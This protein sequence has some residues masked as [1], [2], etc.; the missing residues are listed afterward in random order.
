[1]KCL[2]C[3]EENEGNAKFCFKCGH[4]VIEKELP[5]KNRKKVIAFLCGAVILVMIVVAIFVHQIVTQNRLE[6][7]RI[8][9][10]IESKIEAEKA[11]KEKIALYISD[12]KELF[13]LMEGSS[14]NF[15]MLGVMYDTSTNLKE[16]G[17]LSRD[18]FNMYV[19]D[20]CS[21]EIEQ[22]KETKERIDETYKKITNSTCEEEI[23]E[24][25]QNIV[26]LYNDY[27]SIYD[28]LIN[29]SF[30]NINFTSLYTTEKENYEESIKAVER[31]LRDLER[32]YSLEQKESSEEESEEEKKED[33][34]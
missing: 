15:E 5:K 2:N 12:C 11:R 31:M 23:I 1:M 26:N 30:S 27:E 24:L 34:L 16:T 28:L 14:E 13:D 7:E 33:E 6:R 8:E 10:E 18:Y 4:E 22:E 21:E 9:A 29:Q 3:G 25:Q 17:F 20:L 19:A 32:E